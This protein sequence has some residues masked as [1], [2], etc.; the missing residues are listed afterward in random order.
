ML[1]LISVQP[2]E[3]VLESLRRQLADL[4]VIEGAVASLIGAI[5]ACGISNMATN[6]HRNDLVTELKQPLELS[7]TGE[8]KDGKPHIHCVV[9][10]EGNA[11]LGGHLHWARVENFF[12]NAYVL[13]M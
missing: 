9:S 2:G 10:G 4:G 1:L 13:P 7:G 5:D 8:I 3:E 6:D 11:A 12:V